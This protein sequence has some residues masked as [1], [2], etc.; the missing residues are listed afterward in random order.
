MNRPFGFML[1]GLVWLLANPL[2]AAVPEVAELTFDSR[3]QTQPG[4]STGP[5]HQPDCRSQGASAE[6]GP[7]KQPDPTRDNP[8]E[9][10]S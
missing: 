3:W 7:P 4:K 6:L 8:F 2:Q 10:H 5:E 1:I 9:R